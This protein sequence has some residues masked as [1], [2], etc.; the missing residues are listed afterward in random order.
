MRVTISLA[1]GALAEPLKTHLR[2]LTLRHPKIE[3]MQRQADAITLLAC[4]GTLS[5]REVRTARKRL[6]KKIGEGAL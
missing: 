3:L 5:E 6:A 1:F 2:R 4:H